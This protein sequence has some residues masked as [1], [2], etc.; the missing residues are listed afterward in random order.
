MFRVLAHPFLLV[1]SSLR[2]R[3]KAKKRSPKWRHVEKTFLATHRMCAACG[4]EK[5]LQVHHIKPFHL[6]PELELDQKNLITL[7]MTMN[8]CHLRIGHGGS[9]SA[10]DP[11]VVSDAAQ[12]LAYPELRKAIEKRAKA[13]RLT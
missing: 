4:A 9:F 11:H 6:H 1:Q 10:Y 5:R 2:E 12:L 8:E 13:S 7:C 3:S